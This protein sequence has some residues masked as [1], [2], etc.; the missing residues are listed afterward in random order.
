MTSDLSTE[1]RSFLDTRGRLLLRQAGLDA[2]SSFERLA[3]G[4]NNRVYCVRGANTS[5]VAKWYFHHQDDRRDRLNAEYAFCEFAGR[6]GIDTVAQP[7]ARS[8]ADRLAIYSWLDGQPLTSVE[9]TPDHVEQAVEFLRLLNVHRDS[10][11]ALPVA[12]EACFS[13]QQHI[14]CV[15]RR[16]DRLRGI[17]R[18]D[19]THE[20]AA[21][22][23]NERLVP[24]L[25]IH[26]ERLSVW[27]A[28]ASID[29]AR[30]L[31]AEQRCISPS[32]FGFHNALEMPDGRLAFLDFEYAG[33]DD[34]GK[35][36]CDFFC[37]PK[38]PAPPESWHTFAKLSAALAGAADSELDRQRTLLPLYRIKWCCILLNEFAPTDGARRQFATHEPVDLEEQLKKA[39]QLAVQLSS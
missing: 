18:L 9:V 11:A 33:W 31:T 23:V 29:V 37:Q 2:G 17:P 8:N 34:P 28:A 26:V 30:E 1:E 7:L 13:L 35:T 6:C 36:I 39:T 32:D 4:R 16:V 20:A 27:A 19:A 12:S 10:A 14:D 3:G 5:A 22:L 15:T 21:R 38:F 24:L 25:A